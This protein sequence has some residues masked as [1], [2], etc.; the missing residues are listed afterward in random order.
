MNDF[1]R[2]FYS[3]P[4]TRNIPV[5]Y[6]SQAKEIF[7]KILN[8]IKEENPYATLSELLDEPEYEY[9]NGTEF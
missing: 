7:Q 2:R 9:G 5:G 3:E 8:D 6:L 4:A 1:E